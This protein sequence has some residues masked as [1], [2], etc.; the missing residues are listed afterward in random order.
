MFP[1]L[2]IEHTMWPKNVRNLTVQSFCLVMLPILERHMHHI[3]SHEALTCE[4]SCRH[5]SPHSFLSFL[6]APF[7][8]QRSDLTKG[9]QTKYV[10]PFH[11]AYYDVDCCLP[12]RWLIAG[13]VVNFLFVLDHGISATP[14]RQ[15]QIS[16]LGGY[17]K[18]CMFWTRGMKPCFFYNSSCW[19]N[20]VATT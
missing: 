4:T 13:Q 2:G 15:Q 14:Q 16:Q 20:L 18:F 6:P 9:F 1:Q 12:H 7:S 8:S 3:W 19:S 5:S 10:C 17:W 11:Q